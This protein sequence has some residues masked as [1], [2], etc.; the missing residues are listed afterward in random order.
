M[1]RV[2]VSGTG[3]TSRDGKE[4]LRRC[5]TALIGGSRSSASAVA[6][7][8]MDS[9][10]PR[11][12]D[13][14]G[15]AVENRQ[16]QSAATPRGSSVRGGATPRTPATPR[17]PRHHVQCAGRTPWAG[18]PPT[19]G[20]QE[21][22]RTVASPRANIPLTPGRPQPQGTPRAHGPTPPNSN[23]ASRMS[24]PRQSQ[25]SGGSRGSH[26]GRA[27]AES[28]MNLETQQYLR[29]IR[30]HASDN[31]GSLF[32][33]SKIHVHTLDVPSRTCCSDS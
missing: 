32:L 14:R 21:A 22:H 16:S 11:R 10:T 30:L 19:T 5:L 12:Q 17:A 31:V 15:N 9:W 24:T 20:T 29:G 25:I 33:V 6:S 1:F 3:M 8:K 4:D 26:F 18:A 23:Q 7:G 28:R 13:S 27:N 2:P